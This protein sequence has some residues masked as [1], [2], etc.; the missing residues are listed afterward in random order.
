MKIYSYECEN[1]VELELAD[2]VF[3][4][5][6]RIYGIMQKNK[7]VFDPWPE[8]IQINGGKKVSGVL[9]QIIRAVSE[10]WGSDIDKVEA[11]AAFSDG[12]KEYKAVIGTAEGED[13][14][15]TVDILYKV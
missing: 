15:M 14:E 11:K 13:V 9:K 2:N 4:Y 8:F 3:V 10:A 12:N 1:E 6:G 7:Q 5:N